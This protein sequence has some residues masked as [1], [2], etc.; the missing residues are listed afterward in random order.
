MSTTTEARNR[1]WR[2][3]G[4]ALSVGAVLLFVQL[5][6]SRDVFSD[7]SRPTVTWSL[8]ALGIPAEDHGTMIAVGRLEV[9]WTRDCAGLNLLFVLMAVTVWVNRKQIDLRLLAKLIA[10]VPAA[11]VANVL[12]VLSLIGVREVLYPAVESPQ[13]HYFLGL[14]WLVPFLLF[15]VPKGTR[16]LRYVLFEAAHAA[17]VV[18][19]LAPLS[20]VPGGETVTLA[21]VICLAQCRV[22]TRSSALRDWLSVCW[23][24]A[25]VGISLLGMESFWLPWLLVSPLLV[26]WRWIFSPAGAALTLGSYPLV[27]ML[28]GGV[29]VIWAAVAWYLWQQFHGS[30]DGN[31]VAGS[32]PK[33]DGLRAFGFQ[34]GWV[35]LM[36]PFIAST[37]LAPDQRAFV[38]PSSV[39]AT[40][41]AAD[42]YDIRIPGQHERIGLVWFNPSG[43]GRHHSMKV[44]MKFRG[45][46]LR[47]TPGSETV[48]TD[49]SRWM[50]EFFIIDGRLI[51]TYPGYLFRTLVPRSSP[52]VHLIFFTNQADMGFAEFDRECEVLAAKLV[53]A[54]TALAFR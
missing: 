19:L 25:A 49:G 17:A 28:P 45:I 32:D 40:P 7:F 27:G 39:V 33:V 13:L 6:R 52:G 26:E 43:N 5:T 18:A 2:V 53:G 41:L 3:L 24:L 35:M 46:D 10:T 4:T 29:H 47:P 42:S 31:E 34:A 20:G 8:H 37:L 50:R 30:K 11:L 44:C 23:M 16:P 51:P 1:W 54:D 15:V 38:P 14:I 21:A 9:P 48:L 22:Q 12:R 36:L